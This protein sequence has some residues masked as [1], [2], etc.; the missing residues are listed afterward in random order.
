MVC[1]SSIAVEEQFQLV[2]TIC[3]CIIVVQDVFILDTQKGCYV[4]VGRGANPNERK[5]GFG[6]AHVS[7][8]FIVITTFNKVLYF[9]YYI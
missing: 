7:C 4:W 9:S 8:L 2:H 6:Y 3:L 5:N 1:H